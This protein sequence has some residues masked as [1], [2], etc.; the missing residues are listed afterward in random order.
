MYIGSLSNNSILI[1]SSFCGKIFSFDG[2]ELLIKNSLEIKNVFISM[3][4]I[5]ENQNNLDIISLIK[6]GR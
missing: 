6:P 3:I 5:I 2:E 4:K 1:T